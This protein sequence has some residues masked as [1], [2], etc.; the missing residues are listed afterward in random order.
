MFNRKTA[1]L[2]AVLALVA[3]GSAIPAMALGLTSEYTLIGSRTERLSGSGSSMI[4]EATLT[5]GRNYKI[6]LSGPWSADFDLL[7][8]D[9]NGNRV[10]TGDGVTCDEILYVTPIW[11]G[12]F[13]FKVVS[14]RGSGTF[15]LRLYR[16]S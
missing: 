2:V 12:T 8:Y 16:K 11:T 5:G 1:V 6:T 3:I 7:I 14:Y 13:Y 15:T 9:E 4:F 10:A